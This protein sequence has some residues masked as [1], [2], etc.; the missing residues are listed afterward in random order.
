MNKTVSIV[1]SVK[2]LGLLV[3]DK[4]SWDRHINQVASK[5]NSACYAVQALT[6]LLSKTALKMLYFSYV[7]TI[8]SYGIDF[9]GISVNSIK[10]FRLQKKTIRIMTR[11]KKNGIV[12]KTV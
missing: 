10:I 8:I 3:D 2:C 4:L 7:H 5:L 11:S 1:P 6:P 12:Q 9:W